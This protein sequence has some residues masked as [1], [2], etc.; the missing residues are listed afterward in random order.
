[1]LGI[2]INHLG[3]R[4]S[5]MAFSLDLIVAISQVTCSYAAVGWLKTPAL[6]TWI[7]FHVATYQPHSEDVTAADINDDEAVR[8]FILS[9]CLFR[10]I[11]DQLFDDELT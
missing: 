3:H 1:M 5:D 6:L 2:W 8:T 9:A 7:H 4:R 11:H 10:H